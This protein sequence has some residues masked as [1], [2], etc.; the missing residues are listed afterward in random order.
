MASKTI[1][2]PSSAKTQSQRGAGP[3]S[4]IVSLIF[5]FIIGV[6][7]FRFL[8]RL[9]GANPEN[10]LVAFIYNVSSPLVAPFFGM[11]R[12]GSVDVAIGRLEFETLIAI[13][14]YGLIASLVMGIMSWGGHR[15]SSV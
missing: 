14:V 5:G 11:F 13:V 9:L 7:A 1:L 2:R 3:L 6:L 4:G 8:F 10:G 12:T 15:R